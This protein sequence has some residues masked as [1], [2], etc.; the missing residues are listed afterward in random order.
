M[1][2]AAFKGSVALILIAAAVVTFLVTASGAMAF[3]FTHAKRPQKFYAVKPLEGM[4]IDDVRTAT[5]VKG[6]IPMWHYSIVSP[7]DGKTYQGLM[8]GRSPLAGGMRT[9]TIQVFVVPTIIR[10]SDG[11][12]F[13]PTQIDSACLSSTK[14]P[15]D[16][17]QASPLFNDA[18]YTINGQ[19]IGITQYIDAFQRANFYNSSGG[20]LSN[21]GKTGDRYHTLFNVTMASPITISVPSTKGVHGTFSNTCNHEETAIIDFAT[22][23][24]AVTKTQI[25][26]LA[27]SGVGP[28]S[29]V[30]FMTHNVVM[31]FPFVR[32]DPT[33]NCCI[34]GYHGALGSLAKVQTYA[35]ADLDTTGLWDPSSGVDLTSTSHEIGEWLDDPVPSAS[36]KSTANN[37]APLWGG[38]G[39]TIG[40]CQGNLEVG[41][42]LSG[43][44]FPSIVMNGFTYDVQELA[45]FSWF[46]RQNPSMAAG[47]LFSD[48]GSF[49]TDAGPIC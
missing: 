38:F 7:I 25:P 32:N 24:K 4:T 13:D 6:T 27:K 23:D 18:N 8:V 31:S 28:T 48:S 3:T 29:F 35:A 5:A 43:S 2:K 14:T 44:N 49:G 30:L 42:P 46:Y 41:D 9:T 20:M 11:T 40:S 16:V 39:Q 19:F 15:V 47:G 12:T 33:Q 1:H 17:M 26:K 21:V 45:F 34:L 37:A 22:F 36:V 10:L